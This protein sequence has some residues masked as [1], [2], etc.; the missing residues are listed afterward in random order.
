M[1][2]AAT[3]SGDS[4]GDAAPIISINTVSQLHLKLTPTNYTAWRFQFQTILMGY[5]LMRF[6][7]GSHPCPSATIITAGV[8]TPNPAHS[9]WVRQD[10]LLMNAIV[11]SLSLRP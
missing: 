9:R 4:S 6:V 3:I 7:D 5:D 1:A 10:H 11:S 8:T 2:A